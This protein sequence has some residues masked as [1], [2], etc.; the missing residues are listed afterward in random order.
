MSYNTDLLM[1]MFLVAE[2]AGK[3]VDRTFYEDTHVLE[4]ITIDG[5]VYENDEL[6]DEIE[7]AY[8]YYHLNDVAEGYWR[9]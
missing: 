5:I 8:D 9:E 7:E 1:K 6:D 2:D 3:D 4:S